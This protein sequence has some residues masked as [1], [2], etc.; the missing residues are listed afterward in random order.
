MSNYILGIM[1]GLRVGYQ[2]SSAALL[3]DGE[4]IAF[5][6]EERLCRDKH[7]RSRLP[8]SAINWILNENQLSIGDIDYVVSHGK[9][10]S[11]DFR[12][13]LSEFFQS[14]FGGR[15]KNIE[16]FNHHDA[17][18][19]SAYY[20]SGFEKS[21]ILSYDLSGDG[22]STQL[23]IGENGRIKTIKKFER[24]K[25]LGLFYALITEYC[26]FI[27]DNDEFK[28]MGLAAYGDG[29]KHDF[30]WLLECNNGNYDL[31]QKY[32]K[33]YEKGQP[34]P[35]KQIPIYNDNF[36]DKM[37]EAPRN[38]NGRVTQYYIDIAASAQQHFENVLVDIVT[39]FYNEYKINKICLAGGCA[40]NVV[41]NKRIMELDFIDDLFIQ[42]AAND[43]GISLGLAYLMAFELGNKIE[44]LNNV[45]YGPKYNN[46]YIKKTLKRNQISYM[47]IDDPSYEAARLVSRGEIIGWFQGRMEFGPRALGNRSILANPTISTMKDIV[48]SR[49][50]FREPF[51]PFCPSVKEEDKKLFFKG[52]LDVAPYMAIAYDVKSNF[53]DRI[54]SVTHVDNTARI[55]TVNQKQNPLFYN[56]LENL[57]QLIGFGITLNTSFNVKGQAIVNTPENA[58]ET[59]YG[60]GLDSLI[61]GDYLINKNQ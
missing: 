47:N 28:L 29:N 22:I 35:H 12:I 61:V 27:K 36:L 1:G 38:P 2:D 15:P 44:P 32:L 18:C 41:A 48:N 53:V 49:I 21:L 46:D 23:A 60:S 45:Y 19:A 25:S 43:S 42:P 6:E 24:P 3:K 20:A 9:S 30:N 57:N 34:G 52:K 14:R 37:K 16:L 59:F 10:W 40:L 55:Q 4:L 7:S 17:H 5:V 56:Y 31:N 51:R 33:T 50:K 58:I 11:S 13:L 26:G 8:E 39:N 54:P